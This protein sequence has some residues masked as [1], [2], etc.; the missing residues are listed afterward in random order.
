MLQKWKEYLLCVHGLRATQKNINKRLLL[1]MLENLWVH[2]IFVL[3]VQPLFVEILLR[4]QLTAKQA[5]IIP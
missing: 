3:E 1:R 2:C 5:Q 4:L